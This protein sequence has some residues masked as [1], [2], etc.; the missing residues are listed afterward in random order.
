MNDDDRAAVRARPPAPPAHLGALLEDHAPN[1]SVDE[2]RA[3]ARTYFGL[4][5]TV[6]PLGGERDRN[7]RVHEPGGR[8]WVLKV[9][10]PAEPP[11]LG[12][13]QIRALQ[14][15]AAVDPG[16]SVPRVRRP[17]ETAPDEVVWPPSATDGAPRSR[18]RVYSYV[19]GT[20][21][22]AVPPS[23]VLRTDLGRRLGRLDRALAT[24]EHPG[25][26]HDLIWDAGK[27]TRVRDLLDPADTTAHDLLTHFAEHAAPMLPALRHQVIHNDANPQNVMSDTTGERVGGI[28]DFGDI[29]RAP[30][31]QEVATAS[32]YQ[33]VDGDTAL[34]ACLD[35][36]S[37]YHEA[38]P[39]TLAEIDVLFDLVVARLVLIVAITGWRAAQHPRNRHYI[40]RNHRRARLGLERAAGVGCAA[41]TG[42]LRRL[43]EES[44]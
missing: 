14:H 41:A 22:H 20:P 29:I 15:I 25:A 2:A 43:L 38:N 27:A 34:A 32:A 11:E 26:Q 9:V 12:D 16:L 13:L 7:F 24:F 36:V 17:L 4:D 30:L 31:V 42:E 1:T 10:H 28:I 5:G 21:L 33:L 23:P 6:E 44:P 37:G 18:V 19:P 8:A 35:V 3:L 39:L 40:L